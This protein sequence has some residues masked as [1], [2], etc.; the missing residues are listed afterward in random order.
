MVG[1]VSSIEL[2]VASAPDL[3]IP[4]VIA[5]VL[6]VVA[7][8]HLY[9]EFCGYRR[10]WVLVLAVVL[11]VP[12]PYVG[13]V[14]WRGEVAKAESAKRVRE[15]AKELRERVDALATSPRYE[16]QRKIYGCSRPPQHSKDRHDQ[17]GDGNT[18]DPG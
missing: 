11:A 15:G 3:F 8:Q 7:I 2:F 10:W 5:A 14:T 4:C 9:F 6:F 18:A 12:L 16:Q 13:W 1:F 17:T